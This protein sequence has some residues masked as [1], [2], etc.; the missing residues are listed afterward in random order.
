MRLPVATVRA[1]CRLMLAVMLFAQWAVAA[2]ACEGAI[3][4][5][6]APTAAQDVANIMP[7]DCA[8]QSGKDGGKD[9]LCLEHCRFGQ[10]SSDV[11]PAPVVHAAIPVF[12]YA[13]PSALPAEASEVLRTTARPEQPGAPPP[14][15]HAIAHCVWRI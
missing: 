8:A 14:A 12:L 11:N 1:I 5:Q 10:Q 15:P 9:A 13:L 6:A 4:M 3:A 7:T 2:Y